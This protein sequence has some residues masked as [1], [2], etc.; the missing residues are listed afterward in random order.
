MQAPTPQQQEHVIDIGVN[1]VV[2][3]PKPRRLMHSFC[4]RCCAPFKHYLL[5]VVA[6]PKMDNPTVIKSPIEIV[7]SFVV[8]FVS[9]LVI[10]LLHYMAVGEAME[11]L[12][13]PFGATAVLIY[14]ELASP[15]AQPRNVLIGHFVSALCGV[16]TRHILG[17]I[18]IVAVP[19]AVALAICMMQLTRTTHPPGGATA[20]VAIIGHSY[21]WQ[22]FLFVFAPVLAGAAIM[23]LL[24]IVL[25]NITRKYPQYY[26]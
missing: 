23:V 25:N 20:I 9:L 7:S 10:C 5:K 14:G 21:P 16:F 2:V 18:P 4:V 17:W 3:E 13:A 12:I 15:L 8:T 6:L 24:A 22:G 11:M 19:F 1:L 26:L